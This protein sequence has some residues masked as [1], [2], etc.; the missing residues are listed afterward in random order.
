MTDKN[1]LENCNSKYWTLKTFWKGL[2]PLK[3]KISGK[4]R[5]YK[6]WTLDCYGFP[7]QKHHMKN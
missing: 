5:N 1:N 3:E 2:M 4:R 7:A 6:Y